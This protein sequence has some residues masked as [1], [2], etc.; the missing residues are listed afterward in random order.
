MGKK[1]VK[2]K[3]S[4]NRGQLA[5]YLEDIVACVKAGSISVKK[6]DDSVTL[7]LADQI[8]MEIEAER[9]K[10]KSKLS[11]ELEWL[12]GSIASEERAGLD[13]SPE[14]SKPIAAS[15]TEEL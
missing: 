5:A 7:S 14:G 3:S 15:S 12:S 8:K 4:M 10:D 11:L 6:G 1:E 13:I 2:F 9:K